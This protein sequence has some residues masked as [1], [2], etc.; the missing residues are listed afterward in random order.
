MSL[1]EI[2]DKDKAADSPWSSHFSKGEQASQGVYGHQAT[3][4]NTKRH[5]HP[6]KILL[7]SRK[8]EAVR[9][10]HNFPPRP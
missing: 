5:F 2:V 6:L 3:A 7:F 1:K 8:N 10:G 4:A 9:G